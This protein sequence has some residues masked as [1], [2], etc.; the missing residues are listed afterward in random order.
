MEVPPQ[1]I[2]NLVICVFLL[3]EE[4]VRGLLQMSNEA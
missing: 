4:I 1:I 2:L 3:N